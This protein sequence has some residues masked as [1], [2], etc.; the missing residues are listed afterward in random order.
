MAELKTKDMI[1]YLLVFVV[2]FYFMKSSCRNSISGRTA[3]GPGV[4]YDP[5][6]GR[7]SAACNRVPTC[8]WNDQRIDD[9]TGDERDGGYCSSL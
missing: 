3:T 8:E 1:L 9:G 2:V 5:C 6:G 7:D 4:R